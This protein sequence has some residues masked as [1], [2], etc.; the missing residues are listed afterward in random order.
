LIVPIA[1]VVPRPTNAGTRQVVPGCAAPD[2]RHP[3]RVACTAPRSVVPVFTAYVVVTVVAAAATTFAA[4]TDF[5]RPRWLLANMTKAGVPR[6]WLAPLGS[7]KAAGALGL[8][9]GLGVP[10]LGVV[11]AA[12]LVLFFV[13]AILT[14]IRAHWYSFT[15]PAMFLVLAVGSLGLRLAS[16]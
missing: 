7:L 3:D 11:A 2:E 4:T 6:S 15:Y 1:T 9:V 10:L 8:L 12:G 14:H 13:G 5:I 16:S